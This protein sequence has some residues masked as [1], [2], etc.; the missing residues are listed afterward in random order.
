MLETLGRLPGTHGF[1]MAGEE[2]ATALLADTCELRQCAALS[3]VAMADLATRPH[4]SAL[5]PHLPRLWSAL[6][7]L[8]RGGYEELLRLGHLSDLAQGWVAALTA[9]M[10]SCGRH[11]CRSTVSHVTPTPMPRRVV[12]W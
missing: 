2:A 10:V 4:V 6:L 7:G 11:R 12:G 1:E 9:A 8:L 5:A 3:L